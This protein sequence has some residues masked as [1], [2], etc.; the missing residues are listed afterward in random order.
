MSGLAESEVLT[1]STKTKLLDDFKEELEIDKDLIYYGVNY[2]FTDVKEESLKDFKTEILPAIPY[3]YDGQIWRKDKEEIK[4]ITDT[5]FTKY[6][7]V[8]MDVSTLVGDEQVVNDTLENEV[9]DLQDSLDELDALKEEAKEKFKPLETDDAST[10]WGKTCRFNTLKMYDMCIECLN[11]FQ[12]KIDLEEA[13]VFVPILIEF[14]QQADKTGIDYG[15]LVGGF[16]PDK[17]KSSFYE[18]GDILI[19]INGK[20][21][22]TSV[23]YTAAKAENPESYKVKVLRFNGTNFE[24]VEG[25]LKEPND[26]SA[27]FYDICELPE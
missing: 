17:Q 10:L 23:D 6:Q 7:N 15:C 16:N 18:I 20:K 11:M 25:E 22:M 9:N 19:E 26:S 27:L 8:L 2:I 5:E 14:Y 3:I 13:D 4:A 24:T 12:N 21:I 1:K